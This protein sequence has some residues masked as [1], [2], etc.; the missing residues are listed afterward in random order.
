MAICI[1]CGKEVLTYQTIE[2]KRHTKVYICNECLK[3]RRRGN[4]NNARDNK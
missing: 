2:T 3:K 4:V 1:D